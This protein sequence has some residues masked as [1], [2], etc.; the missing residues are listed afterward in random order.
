M[1]WVRCA[2]SQAAVE[3]Y[4]STALSGVD[5]LKKV[6]PFVVR[7]YSEALTLSQGPIRSRWMGSLA[8]DGQLVAKSFTVW[9]SKC[10]LIKNLQVFQKPVT[11]L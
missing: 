10:S 4:R 6:L 1:G 2:G 5:A 8:G 11:S 7:E 9:K 3:G